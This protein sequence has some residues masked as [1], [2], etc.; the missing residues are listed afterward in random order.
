MTIGDIVLNHRIKTRN[1]WVARAEFIYKRKSKR[2]H[3]LKED[4]FKH[5]KQA[6][7]Q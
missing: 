1:G 6:G 4:L 5:N 2:A 3:V 7:V